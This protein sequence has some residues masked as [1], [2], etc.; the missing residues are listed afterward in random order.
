M[1]GSRDLDKID[2]S[3]NSAKY[4]LLQKRRCI[5]GLHESEIFLALQRSV[6][7]IASDIKETDL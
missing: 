4:I 5:S 2:G 6:S 3:F 1:D 7:H